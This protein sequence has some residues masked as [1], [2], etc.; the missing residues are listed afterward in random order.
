MTVQVMVEEILQH[1]PNEGI[2]SILLDINEVQKTLASETEVLTTTSE[3]DSPATNLSWTLPSTCKV[4]TGIE[5]YDSN[6]QEVYLEDD[7]ND[8]DLSYEII[9]GVIAFHSNEEEILTRL[10]SVISTAYIDYIK[11][12][13]AIDAESDTFELPVELHE[14]IL[15]G[16]LK[17]LY[18]KYPTLPTPDGLIRDMR[19]VSYYSKEYE[20]YRILG[21]RIG[22]ENK[23]R[24]RGQYKYDVLGNPI[25]I[26][27]QKRSS[28]AGSI[29]A[30]PL[31]DLYSKYL[32]FT[33]VSPSTIT[34]VTQFGWT[35]AIATPTITSN[36][37]TVASTAE[38]TATMFAN[39][40]IGINHERTTTSAWTFDVYDDWGTLVVEI[41]ELA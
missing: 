2:T 40:N 11:I 12:P 17:K 26:R 30:T 4:V 6:D 32:K 3:L 21:K 33:A 27:R 14:G 10:P 25:S 38:F 8:T 9:N 15:A 34:I 29:S 18:L 41:Y 24:I 19:M 37:I 1:F 23:E 28:I 39:T 5:L 13:A 20:R 31:L 35:T 7:D 36:V 16:V 22:N